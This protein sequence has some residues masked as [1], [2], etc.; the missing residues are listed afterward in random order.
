MM[1]QYSGADFDGT[2]ITQLIN[3]N[4]QANQHSNQQNMFFQNPSNDIRNLVQNINTKIV[5]DY[6]NLQD[7]ISFD[8]SNKSVESTKKKLNRLPKQDDDTTD[9]SSFEKL[10]K[11]LKKKNKKRREKKKLEEIDE[12]TNESNDYISIYNIGKHLNKD[13]KELLLIT[14]IYCILSTGFAKKTIGNYISYVNPNETGKYSFVG[15]ILYGF[16]LAISYIIIKK[17]FI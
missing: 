1:N 13:T 7:N 17:I 5:D 14:F 6:S 8:L 3:D 9:E 15:I 16:I 10:K 4:Q 12:D 2:P 11:K